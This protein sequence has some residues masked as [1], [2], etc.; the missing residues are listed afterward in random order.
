MKCHT[1]REDR[2]RILFAFVSTCVVGKN[3]NIPN[4][5][6]MDDDAITLGGIGVLG[7][8]FYICGPNSWHQFKIKHVLYNYIIVMIHQSELWFEL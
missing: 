2:G 1:A 4:G 7:S 5:S 8:L 6:S 3:Q